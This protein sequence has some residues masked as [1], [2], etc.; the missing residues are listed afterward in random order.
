MAFGRRTR[1]SETC[2][3]HCDGQACD[4][5]FWRWHRAAV[6]PE[7][8]PDSSKTPW[9]WRLENDAVE[10]TRVQFLTACGHGRGCPCP[11]SRRRRPAQPRMAERSRRRESGGPEGR[12]ER[13]A[14]GRGH[15]RPA[16]RVTSGG[17]LKNCKSRG[18]GLSCL[19]RTR[20]GRRLMHS[21]DA[22]SERFDSR[23]NQGVPDEGALRG[24]ALTY[25][26]PR[27]PSS[28]SWLIHRETGERTIAM[29]SMRAADY[30]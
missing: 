30:R 16:R 7:S 26:D 18:E 8:W 27:K 6:V 15:P 29:R 22:P 21:A 5:T 28:R 14:M 1:R 24:Q 9:R 19:Q 13:P 3:T 25:V 4:S 11:R 2:F 20:V 23:G 10:A 12:S 17:T